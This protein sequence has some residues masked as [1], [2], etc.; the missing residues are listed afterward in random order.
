MFA[1]LNSNIELR[2]LL[3]GLIVQSGNDA[4]IAIAE[5][6]AGTEE[7]FAELLNRRARDV[8]LTDSTFR[9]ASGLHHP[10]QLVTVRDLARLARHI[11][12]EYPDYYPIFAEP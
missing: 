1:E 4:A 6:V 5:G 11:I 10:E 8:G 7:A 9:N 12:R 3:R 2:F